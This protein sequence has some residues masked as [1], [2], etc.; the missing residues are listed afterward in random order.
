[1]LDDTDRET[2]LGMATHNLNVSEFARKSF[3]HRNTILYRLSRV[4]KKTG[5]DPTKFH[6]LCKLMELLKEDNDGSHRH[7][8]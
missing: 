1:M 7:T 6:D 8:G 2:I 5:L 4:R 3:C